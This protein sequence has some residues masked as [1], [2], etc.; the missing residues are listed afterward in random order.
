MKISTTAQ[1][2]LKAL[3]RD[4]DLVVVA[5]RHD[6]LEPFSVRVDASDRVRWNDRFSVPTPVFRT[7]RNLGLLEQAHERVVSEGMVNENGRQIS[8]TLIATQW[9]LSDAGRE[10]ASTM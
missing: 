9:Q 6:N 3:L 1:V 5:L 8:E 10:A 7:M 2:V 4:N